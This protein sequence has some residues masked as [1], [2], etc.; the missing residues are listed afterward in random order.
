[1]LVTK[2]FCANDL[3]GDGTMQ[4]DVYCLVGNAHRTPPQFKWSAVLPER[5]F[6]MLEALHSA[7]G[8]PRNRLFRIR[9]LRVDRYVQSSAQQANRTQII[10]FRCGEIR[11]AD[12]TSPHFSRD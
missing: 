12:D 3:Y 11:T 5:Y 1:G 8:S 4:I 7:A 2:I 6:V 9:F 10:S